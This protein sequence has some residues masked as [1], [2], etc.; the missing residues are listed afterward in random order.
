[1]R[2][3]LN[4]CAAFSD[5]FIRRKVMN[6]I[7]TGILG[8]KD[9][10]LSRNLGKI[11]DMTIFNNPHYYH[12]D[13]FKLAYYETG[14][15]DGVP[16]L[17]VHGWPEL[18]FSWS[19]Q[20][21]ALAAKGYRAIAVDVRGFG[22]SDAPSG[23]GHYGIA[24]IVSDL[25]ALIDH[26]GL[27]QVVLL[28]HDWG[29]IIVWHAARFLAARVSH[30]ISVSTPHVKLSPIDPIEI[31]RKRFGDDHYFVDFHD[32]YGRADKLFAKDPHAFFKMMFR[33]TPQGAVME[34]KHTH[35]PKNY[36]AYVAAGAPDM[37]GAIMSADDLAYYAR[38]YE[39]SGFHG[40][41]NLYRNTTANW[42]LGQGLSLKIPQPSLMV[43]AR[44]DLF[45]P[46]E[47]TNHMPGL[48]PQLERHIIENCGHWVMW[49]QPER[50]NKLLLDWLGR[51]NL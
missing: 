19:N 5:S 40:G 17:L 45:L 31:F 16:I 22:H 3:P 13:G 30:V 47:F 44:E 23:V 2:G 36:A 26:L 12:N 10:I 4:L 29:G 9:V 46:P 11:S 35:I 33:S 41:I 50:L 34:A 42:M 28:G 37:K 49:E 14:P 1:M 48:I 18:A 15:Q 25:E 27:D 8:Q 38:G 24:Q 7:K 39:R 21:P 43:S 51:Q 6:G 20:M 32:N